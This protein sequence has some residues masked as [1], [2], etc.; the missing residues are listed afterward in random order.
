MQ[1]RRNRS[2]APRSVVNRQL[3]RAAAVDDLHARPGQIAWVAQKAGSP[4]AT[5]S[6]VGQVSCKGDAGCTGAMH[7]ACRGALAR[8]S[9]WHLRLEGLCLCEDC[10]TMALTT[11]VGWL[12]Y[13]FCEA[14]VFPRAWHRPLYCTR[15]L[16]LLADW[17]ATLAQNTD[18]AVGGATGGGALLLHT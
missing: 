17:A 2:H 11:V 18:R 6:Q 14:A 8:L 4:A 15:R 9:F 13:C 12:H 16:C 3:P 5:S 7:T 1:L 10:Q